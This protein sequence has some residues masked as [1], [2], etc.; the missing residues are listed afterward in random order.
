MAALDEATLDQLFL[1]A[2]THNTWLDRAVTDEDVRRIYELC[3]WPPT[4]ANT[5]PARFV[6]IRS[7]AG[8]ERL[9]PHLAAGN[10]DKTMNAPCTVIV[11]WD[12][13]FYDKLPQLFPARDLRAGYVGKDAHVTETAFR[14]SS[15]QAA[16]MMLAART[17]GFDCGPMSGFDKAGVDQAFLADQRWKSNLLCNIGYGIEQDLFPRNP[18]LAFDEACLDL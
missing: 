10:V 4:T 14:N 12:A 6:F 3:R 13:H 9:R 17:L 15:L 7:K 1:R 11:A 18:R 8:K 5:N 16:Y 2:R